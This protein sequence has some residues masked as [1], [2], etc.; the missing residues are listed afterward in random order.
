VK[1][2][3]FFLSLLFLVAGCSTHKQ[4][5]YYG[6]YSQEYYSSKKELSAESRIALQH[7]IEEAIQNANNSTTG[8]VAP[9][10]YANLGYLYLK[11]NN[12]QKAIEYFEKEKALYSESAKFMDR[13]IQKV[14]TLQGEQKDEN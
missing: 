13:M 7:S 9:G 5:Y 2:G 11:A 4:L 8:R 12:T 10:L 6:D 3:L 14:K 1:L